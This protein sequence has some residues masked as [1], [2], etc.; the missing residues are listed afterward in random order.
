MVVVE[1]LEHVKE[2]ELRLIIV[3]LVIL[4]LVVEDLKHVKEIFYFVKELYLLPKMK[5][6]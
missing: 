2:I 4:M 6:M 5:L 3:I 1:D